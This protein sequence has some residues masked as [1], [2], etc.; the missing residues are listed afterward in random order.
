[1]LCYAYL[2]RAD[3]TYD[4]KSK[5][6]K[7]T[8]NWTKTS[9]VFLQFINLEGKIQAS[10]VIP[11]SI[12]GTSET[13]YLSVNSYEYYN[14]YALKNNILLRNIPGRGF[15]MTYGDDVVKKCMA[16]NEKGEKFY[17]KK[18]TGFTSFSFINDSKY[19]YVLGANS[20]EYSRKDKVTKGGYEILTLKLDDTA[21]VNHYF[22]KCRDGFIT[23]IFSFQPS[24]N[25]GKPY[26][27]GYIRDYKVIYDRRAVHF[28]KKAYKGLFT[29]KFDGENPKEEIWSY[30]DDGS[31]EPL[32]TKEGKL[33][34]PIDGF[35]YLNHTMQDFE[36]NHYFFG[37]VMQR[38]PKIGSIIASVITSPLI[39]PPIVIAATGGYAKY[40]S[41]EV[42]ILKQSKKGDLSIAEQIE[43]DNITYYRKKFLNY[44][45]RGMMYVSNSVN[46]SRFLVIND[47]ENYYIENLNTRKIEKT[48]PQKE[49]GVYTTILP[50]KEGHITVVEYDKKAKSR[51]LSIEAL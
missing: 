20:F 15:V 37:S 45:N 46:K 16:F 17:D 41:H 4:T 48:I 47:H 34:A 29:I 33:A 19:I 7:T 35:G 13:R 6:G 27:S 5:R 9:S 25:N 12:A 18:L 43:V 2:K 1:V 49:K 32:I 21:Y 14:A 42:L 24:I 23:D 26:I 50:A 30:W 36:G 51:R 22:P 10:K 8:T 3:S 28:Y 44:S 39:L 11:V 40:T 31:Q 38:K